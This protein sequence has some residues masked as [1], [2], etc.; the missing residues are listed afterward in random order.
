MNRL[1]EI[2]QNWPHLMSTKIG[3]EKCF[4]D[5]HRLISEVESLRQQVAAKDVMICGMNETI[6]FVNEELAALFP[7]PSNPLFQNAQAV[8]AN[9]NDADAEC[10]LKAFQ[11]VHEVAHF[12]HSPT[13]PYKEE[14]KKLKVELAVGQAGGR[15]LRAI[16]KETE[17]QLEQMR[18]Q[19]KEAP[20][21][22]DVRLSLTNYRRWLDKAKALAGKEE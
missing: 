5:I 19:L 14:K 2:K 4:L 1:E 15:L 20:P 12:R 11:A 8:C 3:H 13:C 6:N 18:A 7:V 22:E 10:I 17:A 16:Q 9:K 21:L